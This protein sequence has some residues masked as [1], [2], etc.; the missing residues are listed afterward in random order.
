VAGSATRGLSFNPLECLRP[1]VP[2]QVPLDAIPGWPDPSPAPSS[3]CAVFDLQQP[4]Q[5][6]GREK[7][8][9]YVG[10]AGLWLCS[11][12]FASLVF[13]KARI[14]WVGVENSSRKSSKSVQIAKQ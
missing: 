5:L 2:D 13:H 10:V 6:P 11:I 4:R 12:Y 14:N 8:R 9:V 3:K 7:G 1:V